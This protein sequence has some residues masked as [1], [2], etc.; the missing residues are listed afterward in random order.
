MR[1]KNRFLFG[2]LGAA[3]AAGAVQIATSVPARA[4][5]TDSETAQ[6]SHS[7]RAA[8]LT[9]A[10]GAVTVATSSAPG[11]QPAQTNLPILAGTHL[12][13]GDDGQAEIEFEDGS[14]VRLTPNSTLS[15]D[16][17]TVDS[18]G[19]FTSSATLLHGLAYAELRASSQYHYTLVADGQVLSPV[20]NVTVRIS[21]DEPPARF[22]VLD[23][24]AEISP[25]SG[26]SSREL[27]AGET[28]TTS[29]A[30]S[31]EYTITQG[32]ADESWD[33]WNTDRDNAAAAE[34]TDATAVRDGYAGAQG[35]GWADLDANGTWY[36]V[37]GQGQ[38][39]QPTAAF[40]DAG[41]DPYGFGSWVWYPNA[42]YVWASGYPWGWTPYHCGNWNFFSGFGWGWSPASGCGALGWTFWGG[43]RPVNIIYGPSGYRVPVVPRPHP[44]PVH[45]ILPTRLDPNR[46][47]LALAGQTGSGTMLQ[48]GPREIGGRIAMPV[49]KPARDAALP[50][51]PVH[52]PAALARDYPVDLNNHVAVTGRTS[53]QPG[54]V[55]TESGWQR[56]PGSSNSYM[57]QSGAAVFRQRQAEQQRSSSSGM[58]ATPA[59]P[60]TPTQPFGRQLPGT[61]PIY[62]PP[63]SALQRGGLPAQ[64]PEI[65]P[66]QRPPYAPPANP[67][68]RSNNFDRGQ[69]PYTP[70]VQ[71]PTYTPPPQ[72]QFQPPS[73]TPPPQMQAPRYSPPP[74]M[75]HYSPPPPPPRP[76]AAPAPAGRS[77]K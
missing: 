46:Q 56:A 36:D 5:E 26:G 2:V 1:A 34:N 52:G 23:G 66:S 72:Q 69:R 57:G 39:W 55:H 25:A 12:S 44:G 38:V 63:N 16:V 32:I 51:S 70:P 35:Y 15:L 62:M 10:Q 43:G 18:S 73:Y 24:A 28:L 27:R 50:G 74:Q 13:T 59:T 29:D 19:T 14:V 6:D 22:T 31:G 68:E 9:F 61:R 49:Q 45:P 76:A 7:G 37:P 30:A 8:R 64:R 20:E 58:S 33:A 71:R 48:H 40:Q 41:F 77:P 3:L 60:T 65:A 53:T 54:F 67:A 17:L 75:P 11:E 42:G 4:Q 47:S 21:F